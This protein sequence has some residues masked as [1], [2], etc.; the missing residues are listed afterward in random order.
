MKFKNVVVQIPCLNEEACI[1]NV[2]KKI[3]KQLPQSKIIVYDNGSRD[4]SALVSKKHG[5]IVRHVKR[6]GK[7][8]VVR[9]MFSDQINAKYFVMVDGDDTYDVSKL[10]EI[11]ITMDKYNYDMM[12]GKR[13]HKDSSAYR[14]GHII[15]NRFFSNFVNFFF[16]K[17]ITDIFSGFRVFS[18]RFIKTFPLNSREFEIEAELTIHSLE[19]RLAVSEFDCVYGARAEGSFSKL[20]T[21]KDGVK[22][23]KLILILIKDEK[24]LL[25]FSLSSL[26]FLILSLFIGIPV[27][28]D[29]YLTGLVPRMPSAILAGFLMI[30]CFL[31]FFSGLILDIIKKV[32]FENKRMNYLLFKD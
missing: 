2:I 11:L 32:R 25:F 30:L 14:K 7:G 13:I 24:P 9:Q 26:F 1:G 23:L 10:N 6:K 8:N 12:V 4:N 27:I 22:I 21:F 5:A 31:S 29:F 16:G 20:N 15:G 19:Q 18:K 3:K 28:K 17:E